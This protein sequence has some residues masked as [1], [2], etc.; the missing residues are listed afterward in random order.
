MKYTSKYFPEDIDKYEVGIPE[1]RKKSDRIVWLL[2]FYDAGN[3]RDAVRIIE[4]YGVDKFDFDYPYGSFDEYKKHVLAGEFDTKLH[5]M[6]RK[7]E[8]ELKQLVKE[9]KLW[10]TY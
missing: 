5:I 10:L 7:E 6:T 2:R 9:G 1:N 4:K 8:K 3:A